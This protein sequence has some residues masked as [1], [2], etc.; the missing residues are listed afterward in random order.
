V[1]EFESR[2]QV[3]KRKTKRRKHKR[4]A[5]FGTVMTESGRTR[6]Q[7]ERSKGM[8]VLACVM[9]IKRKGFTFGL[10]RKLKTSRE[11]EALSEMGFRRIN[12]KERSILCF[13]CCL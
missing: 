12:F 10:L 13:L 2:K 7:S 6:Q 4:E 8:L 3:V 11:R 1:L 9:H 5:P